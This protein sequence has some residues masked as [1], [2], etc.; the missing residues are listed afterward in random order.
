MGGIV[1]F[2]GYVNACSVKLG[3]GVWST[4]GTQNVWFHRVTAET[5][6]GH[7]L[8]LRMK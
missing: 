3:R 1:S 4:G 5:K 2:W 7:G 8:E 6:V